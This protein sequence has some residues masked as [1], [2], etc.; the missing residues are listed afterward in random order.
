VNEIGT[1]RPDATLVEAY[2]SAIAL[3]IPVLRLDLPGAS[4]KSESVRVRGAKKSKVLLRVPRSHLTL[5]QR[6]VRGEV[7]VRVALVDSV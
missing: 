6:H 1:R 4:R 3:K 7:L 5:V 2:E